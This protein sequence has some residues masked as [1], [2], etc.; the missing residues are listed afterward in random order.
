MCVILAIDSD[1]YAWH[2]P[3]QINLSFELEMLYTHNM[4]ID[5]AITN[6]SFSLIKSIGN[7]TVAYIHNRVAA[8]SDREGI[9]PTI[10]NTTPSVP[11]ARA[12]INNSGN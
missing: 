12:V 8:E 4:A 2:V 11:P 9:L 3:S 5:S 1:A 10:H 7:K 6:C